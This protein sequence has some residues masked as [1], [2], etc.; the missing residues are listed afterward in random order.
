M[1]HDLELKTTN[2]KKP[3]QLGRISLDVKN[4]LKM[5]PNVGTNQVHSFCSPDTSTASCLT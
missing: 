1:E 5:I 3:Y 4:A 2:F